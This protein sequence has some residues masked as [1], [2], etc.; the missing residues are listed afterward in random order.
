MADEE[1]GFM[2]N[3]RKRIEKYMDL[4]LS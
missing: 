3:V 4:D 2:I 1:S